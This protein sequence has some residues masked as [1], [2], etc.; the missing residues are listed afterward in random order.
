MSAPVGRGERERFR[1]CRAV[2][3]VPAVPPASGKTPVVERSSGGASFPDL[4]SAG[5]GPWGELV[6]MTRAPCSPFAPEPP[7]ADA[8]RRGPD[9]E[10]HVPPD[11]LA[12]RDRLGHTPGR[13]PVPV[14]KRGRSRATPGVASRRNRRRAV[15]FPKARA[16][17]PE[18]PAAQAHRGPRIGSG[19]G[20][21]VPLSLD[22]TAPSRLP[23]DR[24]QT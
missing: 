23:Q 2:L 5:A 11:P 15:P 19:A 18:R 20:G 9:R 6:A 14:G 4:A 12:P 8:H 22:V 13:I 10:G 24:S 7:A 3:E 1:A 16:A 17:L 21:P